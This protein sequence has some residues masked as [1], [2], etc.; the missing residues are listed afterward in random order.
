LNGPTHLGTPYIQRMNPALGCNIEALVEWLAPVDLA[1]FLRSHLG[2]MPYA[3]PAAANSYVPFLTWETLDRVLRHSEPVDAITVRYGRMVESPC[4]RSVAQV[5]EQMNAG[6][7]VVVRAA[8]RREPGLATLARSFARTL[9]GEVH[10]Q[11]YATPAGTNSF[12]WHFDFEDVFITQTLGV[13]DYYFRANT[14]ALGAALGAP[15]D[16]SRLRE[17]TS[18]LMTSRLEAG[19][20]LYIPARWWHLVKCVE[21]SLSISIGV[22]SPATLRSAQRLPHGWSGI[23]GA[24]KGHLPDYESALEGGAT[25]SLAGPA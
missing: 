2:K 18:P 24:G 22:M 9:P 4:P 21:D 15:I 10:V 25:A 6:V 7:S 1:S 11:L 13:K 14:V 12:G 17:E 20:W 19:D 8:E 23:M 5:R 16:F 3:R